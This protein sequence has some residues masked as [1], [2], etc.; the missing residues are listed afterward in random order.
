VTVQ[1]YE[2]SGHVPTLDPGLVGVDAT[3]RAADFLRR[4]LA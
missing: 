3:N 2:G 1:Y 4:S